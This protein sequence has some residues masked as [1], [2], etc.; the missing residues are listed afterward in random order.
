MEENDVDERNLN[1]FVLIHNLL[2]LLLKWV[3]IAY[4]TIQKSVCIIILF[5]KNG[6]SVFD[7]IRQLFFLGLNLCFCL[8]L[9]MVFRFVFVH[10]NLGK[11]WERDEVS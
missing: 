11:I 4:F 10:D 1:H 8:I 5:L 2:V 9:D 6:F 7:L 3:C